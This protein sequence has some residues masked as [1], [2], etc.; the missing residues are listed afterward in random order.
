MALI[1]RPSYLTNPGQPAPTPVAQR[2]TPAPQAP[3]SQ[4]QGAFSRASTALGGV[5]TGA[6]KELIAA[7]MKAA[8]LGNYL[9]DM[10]S[11][12]ISPNLDY[13]QIQQLKSR[14]KVG[15]AAQVSVERPEYLKP[16][17]TSEKVGAGLEQIGEFFVPGAA[18]LTGIKAL[19]ASRAAL[20]TKGAGKIASKILP[21]LAQAGTEGLSTL[22][23]TS[24]QRG[25]VTPESFREAGYSALVSP[26]GKL[27]QTILGG[28]QVAQG[29]YQAAQG[30]IAGG[31]TNIGLGLAQLYSAKK[32]NGL[33]LEEP[34]SL[35]SSMR[36]Q[37]SGEIDPTK[38]PK[39]TEQFSTSR[40]RVG[41]RIADSMVRPLKADVDAG[42]QTKTLAKYD[43]LRG[44]LN[45]TLNETQKRIAGYSKIAQDVAKEF[46]DPKVISAKNAINQ[47]RDK[48]V[49]EG[50][51]LSSNKYSKIVDELE[52]SMDTFLPG[53]RSGKISAT[54]GIKLRREAGKQALFHHDPLNKGDNALREE[55]FN[56]LYMQLKNQLDTSLPPQFKAANEA[57]SELIPVQHALLRRIPVAERQNVLSLTDSMTTLASLFDPRALAFGAVS[58]LSKSPTVA[59]TLMQSGPLERPFIPS[60]TPKVPVQTLEEVTAKAKDMPAMSRLKAYQDHAA[61]AASSASMPKSPIENP[62]GAR[63]RFPE[64][65]KSL[66]IKQ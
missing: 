42:Y 11:A 12:A 1:K 49:G 7:P 33:L 54:D 60:S 27:P 28:S 26:L 21:R 24:F 63:S 38:A 59:R 22:A 50:K 47:V 3:M 55:V 13:N 52:E 10:A 15:Q 56:S 30:D 53:W 58:R 14:S 51:S 62:Y 44:D 64:K 6:G 65:P 43:V 57:M 20:A 32:T 18:G 29:G 61:S 35:I 48:F 46:G 25:E 4:G 8:K 9:G 36:P 5:L 34:V 23:T 41:G 2:Q 66:T 45:E 16:H 37:V 39:R 19:Q 40:Q 31:A 17:T